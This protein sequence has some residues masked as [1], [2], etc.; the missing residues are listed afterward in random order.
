ML[1]LEWVTNDHEQWL[2]YD[3]ISREV[4]GSRANW[5]KWRSQFIVGNPLPPKGSPHS[6]DDLK[7]MRLV[8]L[9]RLP[10]VASQPEDRSVT[11]PPL[12]P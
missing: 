2:E 3:T 7:R 11:S 8:G 12:R 6:V 9:Y 5:H 4:F 10:K 1:K